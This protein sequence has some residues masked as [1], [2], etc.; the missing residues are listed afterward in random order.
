MERNQNKQ[1]KRNEIFKKNKQ[2][3]IGKH[4]LR[5][6]KGSEVGLTERATVKWNGVFGW[7]ASWSNR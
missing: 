1:R 7:D 6:K 3:L 4:T 2:I 5:N